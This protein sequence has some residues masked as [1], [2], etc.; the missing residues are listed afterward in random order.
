MAR[1]DGGAGRGRTADRLTRR[2]LLAVLGGG[3][4]AAA[5]G[6]VGYEYTG[7]GHVTGTNLVDQSLTPLVRRR[8]GPSPVTIQL[9]DRRLSFDGTRVESTSLDGETIHDVSTAG[10]D[11]PDA[12]ADDDPVTELLADLP[13][14]QSGN[15]TFEFSTVEAFVDRVRRA[16]ARP[17]SV[18]TLR[19][20]GFRR[21]E[22]DVLRRFA[23]A[24]P[25]A[26]ETLISGLADGFRSRTHFDADRYVAEV[27]E[28]TLLGRVPLESRVRNSTTFESILEGVSG[29]Y[30]A[31]YA[32]RS[33]EA[34]HAV[35]PHRQ[36]IPVF[37]GI[38]V[39][40]R[41]NHAFTVLGSVIREADRLVVPMTFLDF[42]YSTL[43]DTL[44]LRWAFGGDVDAYDEFHR[45]TA[46]HYDNIYG[47]YG[48]G[49]DETD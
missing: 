3:A 5:V 11:V 23:D 26:I 34:F 21:P 38:V 1:T 29:L 15:V 47:Y 6:R 49:G 32:L 48:D 14:L 22:L 35:P 2:R 8:L 45:A 24:D 20:G 39:D 19:G 36:S 18:A 17:L 27:A 33:V 42:F 16:Q 4:L 40:A 7:F 44:S 31:E 28:T 25:S 13:I 37:A 9:A 30:C 41:H 10:S 12:I 46:V 43:F